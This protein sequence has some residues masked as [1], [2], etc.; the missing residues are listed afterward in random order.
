M[1]FLVDQDVYR[2]TVNQLREWWHDV[3]TARELGMQRAGD[4]NLHHFKKESTI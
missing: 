3:V 4:E 2:L 1:R